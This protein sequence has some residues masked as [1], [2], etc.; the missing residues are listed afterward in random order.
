[1]VLSKGFSNYSNSFFTV[2]SA[3]A[4]C[5][6]ISFTPYTKLTGGA[7]LDLYC[8]HAAILVN[9]EVFC[10]GSTPPVFTPVGQV[11][12][13]ALITR[14]DAESDAPLHLVPRILSDASF[15]DKTASPIT[16]LSFIVGLIVCVLIGAFVFYRQS[17]S[18][19]DSSLRVVDRASLSTDT[20]TGPKASR[21]YWT[22]PYGGER[23]I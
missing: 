1:L 2:G 8:P 11:T 3:A 22:S 21:D 23:V 18:K 16:L 12:T 15:S 17:A 4:L 6:Y 14:T 9:F 19:V 7:N 10:A 5:P 13:Q 20:E